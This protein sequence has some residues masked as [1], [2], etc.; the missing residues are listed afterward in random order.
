MPTTAAT[1]ATRYTNF[2]GVCKLAPSA[3]AAPGQ[4]ISR[5]TLADLNAQMG[6]AGPAAKAQTPKKA[7]VEKSRTKVRRAASEACL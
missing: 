3:R 5:D 7:V 6:M 4:H 1:I 2:K